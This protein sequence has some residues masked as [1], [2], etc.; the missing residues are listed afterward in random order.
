M[1]YQLT[2]RKNGGRSKVAENSSLNIQIY[3]CVFHDTSGQNLGQTSKTQW[4]LN[5]MCAVTGLVASCGKDK[6]R[7]L[8]WNLDV[9]KYPIRMSVC[10]SKTWIILIGV[11]G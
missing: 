10:S 8:Y 11:R 5:D 3:G 9:G 2:P 7:K 6:L 1:Q 4:L